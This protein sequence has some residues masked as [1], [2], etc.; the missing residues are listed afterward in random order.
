MPWTLASIVLAQAALAADFQPLTDMRATG[1]YRLRIAATLL[2]RF[3]RECHG[4][5]VR[6]PASPVE[7]A[8]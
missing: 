1:E 7:L 3:W 5:A 2:E 6:L 4:E 8:S